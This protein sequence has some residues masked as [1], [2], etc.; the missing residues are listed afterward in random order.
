MT[1]T[2]EPWFVMPEGNGTEIASGP[3]GMLAYVSTAGGRGRNLAEA[4]ANAERVV[5]CVNFCAGAPSDALQPGKLVI[6][7]RS[8][9]DGSLT[10]VFTLQEENTKLK[11]KLEEM[12]TQAQEYKAMLRL[13]CRAED[14]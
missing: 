12:K 1:H 5:R 9:V 10:D 3:E 2:K 6:S 4:R 8:L 13:S 14:E 11:A 7:F